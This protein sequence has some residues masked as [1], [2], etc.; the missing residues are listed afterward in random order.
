MVSGLA[1]FNHFV[2]SLAS[3]MVSGLAAFNHFVGSL[4]SVTRRRLYQL[5]YLGN[6]FNSLRSPFILRVGRG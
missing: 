4:A 1:A 6:F 3:V 5:S 2:G